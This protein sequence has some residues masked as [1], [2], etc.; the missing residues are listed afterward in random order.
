VSAGACDF[1]VKPV[2]LDTL[3]LVLERHGHVGH[4]KQEHESGAI[5]AL[6]TTLSPSLTA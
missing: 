6:S 3:L 5:F 1:F 2:D 4:L